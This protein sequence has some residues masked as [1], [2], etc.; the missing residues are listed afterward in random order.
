MKMYDNSEETNPKYYKSGF[1]AEDVQCIAI[2][3]FLPFAPGNA[4]KYV[5]RAGNKSSE[6]EGKDLRKAVWYLRDWLAWHNYIDSDHRAAK[7]VFDLIRPDGSDR[8]KAL[9]AIINND[10]D[11]AI[12]FVHKML[13]VDPDNVWQEF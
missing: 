9:A 2:N 12:Y 7:A 3:R 10:I 1:Q 6:T 4:F 8:Y 5:W 13:G 11:S